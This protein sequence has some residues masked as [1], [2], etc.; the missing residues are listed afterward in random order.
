MEDKR[1]RVKFIVDDFIFD[2][3]QKEMTLQER[4]NAREI[5]KDI[6]NKESL[7][8][9]K[10][11]L[12]LLKEQDIYLKIFSTIPKENKSIWSKIEIEDM[13]IKILDKVKNNYYKDNTPLNKK[14]K[15]LSK[16]NKRRK[17]RRTS[18]GQ[19]KNGLIEYYNSLE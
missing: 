5:A 4:K 3:D 1:I 16:K 9:D 11:L 19:I 6:Y 2:Y 13:N 12:S 15:Y 8:K 18:Y 7:Y 10:E 17:Y 14:R